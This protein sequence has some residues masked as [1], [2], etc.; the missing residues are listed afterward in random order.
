[1]TTPLL[2]ADT[3]IASRKGGS[4]RFFLLKAVDLALPNKTRWFPWSFWIKTLTLLKFNKLFVF[5]IYK[6]IFNFD[7]NFLKSNNINGWVYSA[8][9]TVEFRQ[10]YF[11]Y[12][13]INLQSDFILHE[14]NKIF[15]YWFPVP[16]FINFI[17]IFFMTCS[18]LVTLIVFCFFFAH[19]ILDILVLF[20]YSIW[21]LL[22]NSFGGTF[23][24]KSNV[25]DR[26]FCEK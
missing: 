23:R 20:N 7:I 21:F 4:W 10:E 9:S 12:F 5:Y 24:S 25:W 2:I 3:N 22:F 19:L 8:V 18:N 13:N 6:Y 17:Q 26:S 16:L 14:V 15:S 11:I 1:M